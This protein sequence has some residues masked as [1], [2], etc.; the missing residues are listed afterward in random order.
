M[1]R[2]PYQIHYDQPA[3]DMVALTVDMDQESIRNVLSDDLTRRILSFD[4]EEK[5]SVGWFPGAA[6][7]VARQSSDF[8]HKKS[9]DFRHV[10]SETMTSV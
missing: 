4:K 3:K 10:P 7:T 1:E 6:C 8:A 2:L 5:I 9:A